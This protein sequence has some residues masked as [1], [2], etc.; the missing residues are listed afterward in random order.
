MTG[1]NKRPEGDASSAIPWQELRDRAEARLGKKTGFIAENIATL[2]TAEIQQMLHELR[3]HQ[4]ELE[5]QNEALRESHIALDTARVRYFDLYDLAPIGYF[6]LSEQGQILQVNLTAS[7]MLG[8]SRSALV[9]QPFHRIILR[10]DQDIFYL[11]QKHLIES[12]EAQSFELRIMKDDGSQFWA[13][14]VITATYDANGILELRVVLGDISERKQAEQALNESGERYHNLF[15]SIDEGFCVIEMIFDKNNKPVDYC[16]LEVNP[17]FDK[18]SGLRQ[19]LGKRMSELVPE[20]EDRWYEIFGKVALTGQSIR[21]VDEA[22]QMDGRWF[23][24][25]AFRLDGLES[26]KVAVLFRDASDRKHAEAKLNEA[27]LNADKANLAKSEF[28]SSMSHELRTPLN[29][30]LGFAQLLDYDNSTP[31]Q[32]RNIN[33]ILN[34]GWYLLELINEIL[35]LAVIESGKLCLSMEAV[36][37]A[38]VFHECEAMLESLA[39]ERSIVMKFPHLDTPYFVMADRIRLKQVFVN[40]LSNAIKYNKVNGMVVVD[41]TAIHPGCV[42]IS[43]EDTGDGLTAE[44]LMQLFQP[45]NR[46]GKEASLEKG[47]GIGLVVSKRIVELMKGAIGVESTVGQGSVFWVE[48]NLTDELHLADELHWADEPQVAAYVD[49]ADTIA[50]TPVQYAAQIYTI[51][52]VEDNPANLMLVEDIIARRPDINLLSAIDGHQGLEIARKSLPDAILMD[53]S[54]PGISGIEALKMLAEEPLTAHIPVIALSA[55]AI[56]K[57]IE[58]CL[59]AGFISYLTKPIKINEFMDVLD[60]VLKPE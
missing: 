36:S 51:L 43:V 4:I 38:E 17:S 45:F 47:T 39:K 44:N 1:R 28:L 7:S 34:A 46:L 23:D 59:E 8:I 40:L 20:L 26:R 58:K 2:T 19:V 60:A 30:I 3:A 12:G 37:L 18:Q 35:D 10:E 13:S 14:L 41:C 15:N 42:R 49:N 22:R 52:Y 57:D 11:N 55:N 16:Y 54:L 25:Y 50:L 9:K 6:T 56:P 24:M 29:A 5:M 48:L 33:Y 32:K 21:F 31:T 27:K 53:I